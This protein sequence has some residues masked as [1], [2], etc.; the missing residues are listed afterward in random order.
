MRQGKKYSERI[1]LR[2]EL[3]Q[4]KEPGLQIQVTGRLGAK[5]LTEL[6]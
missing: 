2:K 6:S 1:H 5:A 4:M 3:S